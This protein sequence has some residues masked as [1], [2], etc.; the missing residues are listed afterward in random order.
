MRGSLNYLFSF[1]FIIAPKFY[2]ASAI[3]ISIIR[4]LIKYHN[5]NIHHAFAAT[6]RAFADCVIEQM[7]MTG[8]ILKGIKMKCV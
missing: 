7:M 5:I 4:A 1:C 2:G 8:R 3:E 6:I